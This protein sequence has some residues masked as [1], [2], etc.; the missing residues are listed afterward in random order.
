MKVVRRSVFETNSSST[1]SVSLVNLKYREKPKCQIVIK[2]KLNKLIFLKG[3]INEN[4][5]MYD[6]KKEDLELIES[7][8]NECLK[9]FCLENNIEFEKGEEYLYDSFLRRM[10]SEMKNVKTEED[11]IKKINLFKNKYKIKFSC[12]NFF[13]EGCLDMCDCGLHSISLLVSEF[14]LKNE[15]YERL[16]PSVFLSDQ[17]AFCIS[18]YYAGMYF[19]CT[20]SEEI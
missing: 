18:E 1:H 16:E 13:Y 19:E 2:S 9:I 8:F 11:I 7:Y 15:T 17:Y 6:T 4:K 3:L 14:S 12:E 10:A 5:N 20:H